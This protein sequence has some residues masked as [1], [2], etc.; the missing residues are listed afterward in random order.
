M[1]MGPISDS[2][3]VEQGGIWSSW[4]FQLTTDSSIKTL[5]DSRL[6]V[7]NGS[8]SLAA[9]ALADDQVLLSHTQE[10]SQSLIN[11]AVH[12]SSL[13]NYQYILAKTKILV[14]NPKLSK[15]SSQTI[16][17][18]TSWTVGGAPVTILSQATYLWI[19]SSGHYSSNLPA[20]V[21][22]IAAHAR[23]FFGLL[24][25]G[26]AKGHRTPPTTSL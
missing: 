20:V 8:T 6:G 5:N 10:N 4:L 2:R 24:N 26:L 19:V 23:S 13:N 25:L 11:T 22:R 17:P 14:T 9:L 7:N 12:L 18:G 16:P 3:G 21:T 1:V 15:S